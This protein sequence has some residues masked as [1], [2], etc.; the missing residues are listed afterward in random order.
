MCQYLCHHNDFLGVGN[1]LIEFCSL[2]LNECIETV[3]L[4]HR[5][6]DGDQQ[7]MI[8]A[9]V[10]KISS[11]IITRNTHISEQW[12]LLI[13]KAFIHCIRWIDIYRRQL[14]AY[15]PW[16]WRFS[17]SKYYV[18]PYYIALIFYYKRD[19]LSQGTKFYYTTDGDL[20]MVDKS[21]SVS[22]QEKTAM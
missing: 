20:S 16:P 21:Q 6:H 11:Q 12:T 9:P 19:S 5:H 17:W 7:I 3:Q 10:I 1:K 2:I 8:K 18:L 14:L 15:I 13:N 22:C 4:W